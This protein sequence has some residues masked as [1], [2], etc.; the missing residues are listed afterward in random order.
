M[1]T[2]NA[3]PS[4]DENLDVAEF[5]D[6]ASS[7][8]R[9]AGML[10]GWFS[11][12]GRRLIFIA[13]VAF[14]VVFFCMLGM[15]LT[16]RA[17]SGAVRTYE[18]DVL[19][20]QLSAA[21]DESAEF[22]ENAVRGDLG[23]VVS[24]V[25]QR[26]T[27]PVTEFVVAAYGQSAVLLVVSIGVAA[28]LGIAAG[29]LAA[30]RRHSFLSLSTLTLTVVG[31]SI[32]SFF[33]ALLFRIADIRFYQRT[34]IGLFPV[35]GMSGHRTASLLP[36]LVAPALVLAA[37]PL[38]QIARVTFISISEILNRDFIRTAQSKGL[39]SAVVFWR[40]A[41]RNAGV[42]ILTAAVVSLR[43][44]LGSLPVVEIFFE[45][46]GVGSAMLDA[47]FAG[48]ATVVA[49]LGLSLGLTFL[50]VTLLSDILYR[51]IDPRL[52]AQVNGGEA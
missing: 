2:E 49:A 41:L 15:R 39:H 30:A 11:F 18:R 31:V 9:P 47:I 3:S 5:D 43:F 27:V 19:W 1:K 37:R 21:I 32:P 20:D 51:W 45:W 4:P 22:F 7:A 48:R 17:A 40:H 14:A 29:G 23:Y 10:S 36:Q 6:E 38:A 42:S 12:L 28:L 25:T 13:A 33:L 8:P 34:G 44:A 26:T 24:G 35:Y 16:S 52:R 50:L 46:P